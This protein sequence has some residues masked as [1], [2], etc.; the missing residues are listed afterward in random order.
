MRACERCGS[1]RRTPEGE[2]ADCR[3]EA[4]ETRQAELKIDLRR[5]DEAPPAS[6]LIPEPGAWGRGSD[7]PPPAGLGAGHPHG[8]RSPGAAPRLDRN[9]A[10]ALEPH[11][12][13]EPPPAAEADVLPLHPE[14]EAPPA[15]EPAAEELTRTGPMTRP[16]GP[17]VLASTALRRDLAPAEP[18]PGALRISA[19]I[20]GVLGALASVGLCG[21]QG[22][23]LPLGGAFATL[24]ALGIAPM[25]YAARASAVVTVSG[26]GL[27]LVTWEQLKGASVLEP[28]VLLIGVGTLSTALL[29]RA[30]HRG[31]LLARALT[32][33]GLS[34][35]VG[36]LWMA[37]A[38]ETLTILD[39]HW[40]AWLPTV[41]QVPFALILMLSLLAFMDSRST[42]GCA[43]WASLLLSWYAG[44][45]WSHLLAQYWP[46]DATGFE[47]ANVAAQTAA[48]ALA[49]PLFLSLLAVGLAQLLS[50]VTAAKGG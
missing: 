9:A 2:C 47:Q 17:P 16:A 29:Y 11:P 32:L 46:E 37:R 20:L 31:S 43:A 18:A 50:L 49:Q 48:T 8:R 1:T 42:G 38:L 14:S 21:I 23:G 27:T 26:T 7:P 13:S 36:W 45:Q 10:L 39:I 44:F 19:A 12:A 15:D 34:V 6:S 41:L 40:Q 30:W 3:I 22:M 25:G 24:A 5:L 28:F 33:L 35:C 4:A